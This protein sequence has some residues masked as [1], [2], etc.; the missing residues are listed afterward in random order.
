[1]QNPII[2][3]IVE[4]LRGANN[5]LITVKNSPSVDEL[6]ASIALTLILNHMNKHAT[7]VFSGKVPSTIEFLQPE[8]AIESNTD[9]LRDFIIALDKSK[10][11]KLRYKVEDNVVRIFITPYK[12]SISEA[13]LEFSQGDF[14]VDVVVALGVLNRDDFDQAVMAHGRILHDATVL[15]ITNEQLQ[16]E[17]GAVNWQDPEASSVSEMIARITD[18]FG[19]KVIDS[20]IA[21]ALLTGIVAETDRFKNEKTTPEV[22]SISS[23]LMTE[24]A[25]QMLIAE[26]LEHPPEVESPFQPIEPINLS[27]GNDQNEGNTDG[28]LSVPHDQ[29]Q[30]VGNINID[31]QGNINAFG[32]VGDQPTGQHTEAATDAQFSLSLP[33]E[34]SDE[35]G[36]LPELPG[37]FSEQASENQAVAGP[38]FDIPSTSIVSDRPYLE[39][40]ASAHQPDDE[41]PL[42]EPPGL[43]GDSMHDV[44]AHPS[45][46]SESPL[47]S[48]GPKVI[49]PIEQN[50]SQA[51]PQE[52]PIV[53]P[54]GSTNLLS[55]TLPVATNENMPNPSTTSLFAPSGHGDDMPGEYEA[56]A[57]DPIA[58]YTP[59]AGMHHE[60]HDA[61][62]PVSVDTEIHETTT[63]PVQANDGATAAGQIDAIADTPEDKAPET[64]AEIEQKV[65]S[66]HVAE[67]AGLPQAPVDAKPSEPSEPSV[68]DFIGSVR[69]PQPSVELPSLPSADG[70]QDTAGDTPLPPPVSTE[71]PQHEPVEAETPPAPEPVVIEPY[72]PP[73]PLH[74]VEK[75]DD[76][77]SP[78][79]V[80]PPLTMPQAN[81]SQPVYYDPDGTKK[82]PFANPS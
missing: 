25:N 40:P 35:H 60:D 38:Q 45:E 20:Q 80:P 74:E 49:E 55:P 29:S 72:Q 68:D 18:L 81:P 27:N 82:D 42:G 57:S 53:P 56:V 32:A 65:G 36:V 23:M 12:S 37:A 77:N 16:Q 31:D 66:H 54:V 10:A 22:L 8:M 41:A 15:A 79:Q 75:H 6:T 34:G 5:V 28:T 2:Q 4:A 43:F 71:L 63:D 48:R 76:A 69:A 58:P 59:P 17:V 61:D 7:T 70:H 1:M 26:E 11:D 46:G 64:L 44:V 62:A 47:L 9:S 78:P 73:A 21:T 30:P 14:N 3:Q 19:M 33:G 50:D 52:S 67:A 39:S 51:P 13:D 24:G